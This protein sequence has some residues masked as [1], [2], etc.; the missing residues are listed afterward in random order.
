MGASSQFTG[1]HKV[2][3]P[4]DYLN[5]IDAAVDIYADEI[6]AVAA[7]LN[8]SGMRLTAWQY[9]KRFA[10]VILAAW[11]LPVVWTICI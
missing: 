11:L 7:N 1:T 2:I 10:V 4:A 5:S 3:L 8:V 6:G 9:T